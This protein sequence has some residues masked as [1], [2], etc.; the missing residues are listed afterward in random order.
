MRMNIDD[1]VF[2]KD[3]YP[4]LEF[5]NNKVNEYAMNIE[6]LPEI[7]VNRSNILIDGYHRLLAYRLSNIKEIDVT[8]K[9][10]AKE[11]VLWEST[12]INATHGLSLSLEE[13]RISAANRYERFI[14]EG[15]ETNDDSIIAEISNV[16][17]IGK[18]TLKDKWL[19]EMRQK[20]RA[21]RNDEVIELYLRC[22]TQEE[23]A[24]RINISRSRVAQIIIN[25]RNSFEKEKLTL[26]SLQFYNVWS[27]GNRNKKYGLAMKGAI[28][29][30]IVENVLYYYTDPFDIVVDPM[31]GGGTTIDVCK[32]MHRRYRAYD[33]EPKREDIIKYDITNGYPKSGECKNCDLIFLDP[34]YY[35]MIEAISGFKDYDEFLLFI[36]NLAKASH[37]T[38]KKDGIV[39]FLIQDMTEKDELCLSGDSYVL[40]KKA[41]FT[42]ADHISV[43]LSTQQFNP[44]Q[45]EK[46]KGNRHLL[47]RNRDLYIFKKT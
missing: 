2:D 5:N 7:V 19:K 16:L 41:G 20:E 1:V 21:K 43:P 22:W 8:V 36:G 31:A 33:R 34:P 4:R 27:F 14:D 32:A 6:G 29:G 38:V 44:Q 37:Q 35:N 18:K 39:T 17:G 46:A 15:E 3:L 30:Q 11:N 42:C 10:I 40:F 47:G 23:I 45:L 24:E 26:D 25:V 9:D 12:K 28:P 13:K